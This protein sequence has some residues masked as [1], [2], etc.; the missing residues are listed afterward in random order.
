MTRPL[1]ELRIVSDGQRVV[2]L[3]PY[4]DLQRG[5]MILF[6]KWCYDPKTSPQAREMLAKLGKRP[7]AQYAKVFTG[8]DT[9]ER[10]I[11]LHLDVANMQRNIRDLNEAG[12]MSV[13]IEAKD[14]VDMS[15]AKDAGARLGMSR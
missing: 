14:Y 1:V 13:T 12:A 2:V 8:E 15:I 9:L 6:R 4:G 11:D 7:V 5:D 3:L 10:N